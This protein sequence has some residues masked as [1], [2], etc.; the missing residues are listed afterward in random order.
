MDLTLLNLRAPPPETRRSLLDP[1]AGYLTA[2]EKSLATNQTQTTGS[3]R[4]AILSACISRLAGVLGACDHDPIL[5]SLI[6]FISRKLVED[7]EV[8][9]L[10]DNEL[11]LYPIE[12]YALQGTADRIIYES[13]TVQG[14]SRAQTYRNV[15]PRQIAHIVIRPSPARPWQGENWRWTGGVVVAQLLAADDAIRIEAG[16][17]RGTVIPTTASHAPE[18]L[19]RTAVA[20]RA[21]KGGL[22]F[23]PLLGRS[24]EQNG[25]RPGPLR[26]QSNK[27]DE[28]VK[29]REDLSASLAESL[30]FSRVTL[31]MGSGGQVS[32]PDGLRT[33]VA[34]TLTGW[35]GLLSDELKRVLEREVKIDLEPILSRLAPHSQRVASAARLKAQGFTSAE[36]AKLA[37]LKL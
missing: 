36:A 15:S 18:N 33:W 27:L 16:C 17:P 26:L 6:P 35:T 23:L 14:P 1:W 4:P 3:W 30:G 29:T 28:L 34:S 25:P 37:G 9:L 31:G 7:G 10:L 5:T 2:V 8:L 11:R 22:T 24:G 13:V 12:Q 20:L 32:R 21:L 19:S